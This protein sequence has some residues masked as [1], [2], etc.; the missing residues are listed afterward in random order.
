M[1]ETTTAKTTAMIAFILMNCIVKVKT[2]ME[3]RRL[4][5]VRR[6]KEEI[7]KEMPWRL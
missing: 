5:S 1:A 2:T 6:G 7:E 4:K 3:K